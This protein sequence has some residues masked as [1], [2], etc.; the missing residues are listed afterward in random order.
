MEAG[1]ATNTSDLV[2]RAINGA[3]K[4]ASAHSVHTLQDVPTLRELEDAF[5]RVKPNK[6][7]GLD[8]LRSDLCGLAPAAMAEKFFSLLAKMTLNY[9]EPVQMKGGVLVAAFKSGS[10][11]NIEQYR[12]LL[13]SSHIGKSLR[14]TLRQR[15]TGLYSS[16][17]PSLHVSVK[18]GGNVSHASQA[19]RSYIEACRTQKRSVAILFL[20][21]KSA[22]YRVVRQLAAKATN[23]DQD[24]ERILAT[25]DLGTN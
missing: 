16:T 4:R 3:L 1:M 22:Y 13:L 20:D 15:L 10:P 5:R 18:A 12:S 24:V 17:A 25:F 11:H 8:N 14:R 7:A 19:L 23:C 21:I 6:A 9:S 2:D